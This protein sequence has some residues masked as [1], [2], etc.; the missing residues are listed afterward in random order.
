MREMIAGQ[1]KQLWEE[2]WIPE[3]VPSNDPDLVARRKF[4][5]KITMEVTFDI[6]RKK[7]FDVWKFKNMILNNKEY[8][9]MKKKT[10]YL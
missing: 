6:F 2:I 4:M 9:I 1:W 5:M 8:I 7:C 3:I 10:Y